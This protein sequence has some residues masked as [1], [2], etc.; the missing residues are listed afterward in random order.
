MWLDKTKRKKMKGFSSA[1]KLSADIIIPSLDTTAM[2][3]NGQSQKS[4]PARIPNAHCKKYRWTHLRCRGGKS[5]WGSY[6]PQLQL[7]KDANIGRKLTQRRSYWSAA[8]AASLRGLDFVILTSG[9]G[10][11]PRWV[12]LNEL[13]AWQSGTPRAA[14]KLSSLSHCPV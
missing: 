2:C 10:L 12:I 6:N 5:P 8:N 11:L 13:S 3:L 14:A 1:V 4:D 7:D 9:D